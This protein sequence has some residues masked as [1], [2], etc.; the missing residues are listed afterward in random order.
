MKQTLAFFAILIIFSIIVK[1][2]FASLD[3]LVS[4]ETNLELISN[5]FFPC[6]KFETKENKNKIII[7]MDDVQAYAWSAPSIKIMS[8][9]LKNSIP[10][11]IGVIAKDIEQDRKI[12]RFIK[13]N[14]CNLEVAYHGWD[15]NKADGSPE[16]VDIYQVQA[17][18][19]IVKGKNSLKHLTKSSIKTFIP[20][21]N[22]LS[23]NLKEV[24]EKEKFTIISSEGKGK[25]DY[26]ASTY[27]FV[28]ETK[29]NLEDTVEKCEEKIKENNLCIIML[30]PQDYVTNNRLD[31]NKFDTYKALLERLGE[32]NAEFTTFE[33]I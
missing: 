27:D 31:K 19:K 1:E 2:T 3:S 33:K 4:G 13:K 5:Q 21:E 10:M 9:T 26:S 29:N 20:P 8:H 14:D 28:N 16:F 24:V 17:R 30:H 7:R 15:H 11:V 12:V 18:E 22:K 32:L 23:E 6:K 25:Y